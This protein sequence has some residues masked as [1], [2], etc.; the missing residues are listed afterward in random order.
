MNYEEL[1]NYLSHDIDL[2]F[3]IKTM[4]DNESDDDKK[5]FIEI[6]NSF[7]NSLQRN[8]G[9]LILFE[10]IE[11]TYKNRINDKE[12]LK[13]YDIIYLIHVI[14]KKEDI[15]FNDLEY[16]KIKLERNRYKLYTFLT[17]YKN[18]YN[19]KN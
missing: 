5:E 9:I 4:F 17:K 11:M 13:L 2:I 15:L 16:F 14:V 1:V 10:Y 7:I 12:E 3:Q 8:E 18:K 6:Y 19:K